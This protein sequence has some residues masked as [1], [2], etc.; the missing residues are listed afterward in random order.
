[1]RIGIRGIV[2]GVKGWRNRMG[3]KEIINLKC[4]K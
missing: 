4:K 1:M 2:K 3:G